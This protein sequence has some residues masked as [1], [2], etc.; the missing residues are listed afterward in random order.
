[1]EGGIGMDKDGNLN[2][3]TEADIM[4]MENMGLIDPK[5]KRRR[6]KTVTQVCLLLARSAILA[7]SI[8]PA[9]AKDCDNHCELIGELV[10][11]AL[12]SGSSDFQQTGRA[13]LDA[14]AQTRSGHPIAEKPPKSC[15][16]PRCVGI[17][18]E[19][20]TRNR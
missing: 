19:W 20:Q 9:A 17:L 13:F 10:I 8:T 12:K 2:L 3:V 14:V 18:I 16:T 15:D 4:R 11:E 7:S 6:N 5:P 1:M